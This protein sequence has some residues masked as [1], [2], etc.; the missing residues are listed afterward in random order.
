MV[1]QTLPATSMAAGTLQFSAWLKTEGAS[2]TGAILVLRTLANGTTD[3]YVFMD[4]PVTGSQDWH[5]YSV[6]LAVPAGTQVVD[7]GAMLQGEGTMWFD[8]AE[9][10]M[11]R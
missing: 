6:R 5:R 7:A 4:P 2:G 11:L 1:H 3:R 10:V 9:L 8:D